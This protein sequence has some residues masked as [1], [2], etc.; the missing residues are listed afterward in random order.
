MK[1]FADQFVW[2]VATS[3]YQIEGA[4]YEDG[5]GKSIWDTFAAVPGNVANNDHGENACEHYRLYKEDIAIVKSL[6]VQS[7]R[8]SVSWPRVFPEGNGRLND[9]G[10]DFYKRLIDELLN[11]GIDPMLTLYHWDLPQA[12]QD[13]GGWLNRDTALRFADYS[14]YMFEQFGDRVKKWVTINE[15]WVISY[16]GHYT[17]EHAPGMKNISAFLS[18]AHHVLLAHGESVRR[19][20]ESNAKDGNIGI[21]LNMAQVYAAGESE[22]DLRAARVWDGLLN[23][24]FLEPVFKGRYPEDMTALYTHFTEMNYIHPGDMEVISQATDFLGVNYYS[25]SRLK[26]GINDF[27]IEHVPVASPVTDMGWEIAPN[28]LL[29]L[30]RR[31]QSEIRGL[32]I[33]ITENGA[34]FDDTINPDGSIDDDDRLKYIQ[35]HIEVCLRAIAEGINL[36]G[37]YVWSLLDNFEWAFGYAKRFGIVHVDFDTLQRTLKKSAHWYRDFVNTQKETA[38]QC[39][40]SP[41][42]RDERQ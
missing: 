22:G 10:L 9:K 41:L 7:Y 27:G 16:L 40:I 5:K 33:V 13:S 26:D 42:C 11:C 23:R 8:F 36:K 35:D 15:P 28:G 29:E 2:G 14:A 37:Y 18:S 34:A 6:N 31:L 21:V 1:S 20:R 17:G 4:A 12:L 3:A 24:W 39:R 25:V 30:L 19:F 38:I 32:P